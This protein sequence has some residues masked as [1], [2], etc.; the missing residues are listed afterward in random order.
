MCK[1]ISNCFSVSTHQ[2]TATVGSDYVTLTNSPLTFTPGGV[3]LQRITVDITDDDLI[4]GTEQ[5]TASLSTTNS[6]TRIGTINK[7]TV[8]IIDDDG[9]KTFFSV[10]WKAPDGV[11]DLCCY[12]L[13][14]LI[15]K[16]Y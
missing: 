4:E 6:F 7:T 9:M 14:G 11:A 5:F 1:R 12:A 15:Q 10:S 13:F 2:G 16:T 3:T 8:R